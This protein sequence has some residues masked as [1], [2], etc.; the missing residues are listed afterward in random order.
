MLNY[1]FGF[2]FVLL[3][4]CFLSITV[5]I[6]ALHAIILSCSISAA[7]QKYCLWWYFKNR[8]LCNLLLITSQYLWVVFCFKMHMRKCFF[9]SSEHYIDRNVMTS[10]VSVWYILSL[11][12]TNTLF[13]EN[14]WK[15]SS[16]CFLFY[17]MFDG[18]LHKHD[19]KTWYNMYN[20]MNDS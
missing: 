12:H 17:I 13:V 4:A 11:L 1:N 18:C 9:P 14:F 8:R 10:P 16:Y 15:I 5:N 19:S 20:M 6:L 3:I 7:P 2:R